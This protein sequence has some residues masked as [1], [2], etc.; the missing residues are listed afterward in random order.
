MKRYLILLICFIG[1]SSFDP[2][3][4]GWK[5]TPKIQN[6]QLQVSEWIKLNGEKIQ[7]SN[8]LINQILQ[9]KLVGSEY[10]WKNV[11]PMTLAYD[12]IVFNKT[13][14]V[15]ALYKD[16]FVSIK[17]TL[18]G[19]YPKISEFIDSIAAVRAAI[20][21]SVM[22]IPV[23][24][25]AN[26]GGQI[27]NTNASQSLSNKTLLLPVIANYSNANHNHS[28][29][30]QGGLINSDHITEGNT[31]LFSP[32][33]E[34]SGN[35][36]LQSG[37]IGVF[38]N[39]TSEIDV[40]GTIKGT[41]LDAGNAIT[42][43]GNMITSIQ[44]GSS[45]N[46]KIPTKGWVS[47]QIVISGGYTDEKAQDAIGTILD[48]GT[49]GDIVFTYD[50]AT[51]NISGEIENDSHNHTGLTISGLT[52]ADF[53]SQNISQWT[54]DAGYVGPIHSHLI[55]DVT[56]LQ[57]SLDGK[58]STLI[59]GTNIKTINGTS[60]LGSGN[61]T[62]TGGSGISL[63][64]LSASSPIQY[65]NTTG[66]FSMI[67]NAYAPYG[68]VSFPGFG[69]NHTTA[70][71]GDHTHAGV[72]E[73]PLTFSTGLNRTGNTVVSTI[74]QYTDALARGSISLTT[75][76]SSGAATYNSSTGVLNIPQYAG[77]SGMI[78]PTGS[79]IPIVSGG[80]SWGTTITDNSSNWNTAYGWG[81]HA[82]AGYQAT[83]ISG[84]NIKTINGSSLLGA[85]DLTI[86][87]GAGTVTSVGLTAPTGFTVTGSPVTTSGTL[88]LSFSTGYSLPTTAS[89]TNWNT[90]YAWGNH[91]GLYEF[92]LTFSTGLS[93]VGNTITNTVTQYT[94]ALARASI[95]LT[96]N[97]SSGAA[98]Y[99]SSTGILNI[100]QYAGGSGMIWPTGSGIPTV[101]NGNSWG[102]T[103]SNGAGFLRND[104]TGVWSYD[105]SIYDR[106]LRWNF[107]VDGISPTPINSQETLD[108]QAGSGITL[109]RLV[110]G[111]T[112]RITIS[113]SGGG[114]G[115]VTSV[116]LSVPTGLTVTG[117]PITSTGT[118]AISLATGYTIPTTTQRDNWNSAYTNMGKVSTDGSFFSYL[119]PNYF[120]AL[121]GWKPTTLSEP[122]PFS[123][124]PFSAGGAYT[125]LT[126]KQDALSGTGFI[127]ISG[128]TISY[129]NSSYALLNGSLS[130]D[131]SGRSFLLP[132]SIN[133]NGNDGIARLVNGGYSFALFSNGD[134]SVDGI[135]TASELYRG[136]SKELK[137]NIKP[138]KGNALDI[139]NATK[140]YTY[141]LNSD[142]SFGVGFLAEDT[143][144]WLSGEN[145]KSHA[146]GNHLGLL[147]KAIQE[148][149]IVIEEM[150]KQIS[151]LQ[152]EI[153]K[154]KK[155]QLKRK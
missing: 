140:I 63:T 45:D 48:N 74:T 155:R 128:T 124:K 32:F 29:T 72:Y 91:A 109:T 7:I 84:T 100:P 37:K 24:D 41:V 146:M 125:A 101:V 138:Y 58:Q 69:T 89:Q 86:T 50:D 139:L 134:A 118:L 23:Y 5:Y 57:T 141:N 131:F 20:P 35:Y 26:I 127:K 14:G 68:T 70:A 59:S 153:K 15:I 110:S 4:P 54:N 53:S 10:I 73:V 78:W 40:L 55:S 43:G 112:K 108:F 130:Q 66:A 111:D 107:S 150:Q 75:T 94:D 147:T 88:A 31:N 62:V 47:D 117:S 87:G 61:I 28:S 42:L 95:S 96:T 122:T 44:L 152:I 98:T 17:D 22:R 129:D 36:I 27:V 6:D 8:P 97:G 65:N 142:N 135:F 115:T 9:R 79:G 21:D 151:D 149:I 105:N 132:N 34:S 67:A 25:P 92:P 46:D 90:A 123:D 133:V 38:K 60:I 106:Y 137:H 30:V 16:G 2:T 76:G 120:N 154:L 80:N 51:P 19:R 3:G 113:A 145:Q 39:P 64:D 104:G 1:L 143:H 77:G 49:V 136:S 121:G 56:S 103:I 126:A 12:S 71:Y 52:T 93:R 119:N 83:L 82:T 116:G 114:G 33:V 85:G 81:N 99:N 18:D 11:D 148:Q 102:N 13:T 144:K